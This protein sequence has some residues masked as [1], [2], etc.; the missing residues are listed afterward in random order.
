[1][2]QIVL[3][4]LISFPLIGNDLVIEIPIAGSSQSITTS[5]A[6]EHIPTLIEQ[7]LDQLPELL[8]E[9]CFKDNGTRV[10]DHLKPHLANALKLKRQSTLLKLSNSGHD[11]RSEE[12]R[13]ITSIIG[14]AVEQAMVNQEHQST[15]EIRRARD[16]LPALKVTIITSICSIASA[17]LAALITSLLT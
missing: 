5:P 12:I 8:L 1:M 11:D 17:G 9:L 2:K 6:I 16:E 10:R 13:E 4:L 7:E 3:I 15:I 14:Q